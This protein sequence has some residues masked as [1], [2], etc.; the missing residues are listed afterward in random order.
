MI[1]LT[2]IFVMVYS[3]S[4]LSQSELPNKYEK[5]QE[6]CENAVEL[7]T[8]WETI[9]E[10]EITKYGKMTDDLNLPQLSQLVR[11][12]ITTISK[13]KESLKLCY[14]HQNSLPSDGLIRKIL[15]NLY[16]SATVMRSQLLEHYGDPYEVNDRVQIIKNTYFEF[17]GI[18]IP[19]EEPYCYL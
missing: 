4:A 1:K 2:T 5:L 19:P 8:I 15:K 6:A 9:Q 16:S 13:H 14:L 10:F 17:I 12:R 3:L 18:P 7:F 11:N